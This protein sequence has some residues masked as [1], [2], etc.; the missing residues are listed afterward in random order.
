MSTGIGCRQ[1]GVVCVRLL[2]EVGEARHKVALT[3]N[4]A[5]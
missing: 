5:V 1:Q 3:I 2:C 4:A